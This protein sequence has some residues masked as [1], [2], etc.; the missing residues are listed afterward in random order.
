MMNVAIFGYSE[1]YYKSQLKGLLHDIGVVYDRIIQRG[2]TLPNNENAIRNEF[3]KYFSEQSYKAITTTAKDYYYDYEVS[4]Q[5]TSGRVDM[6]FLSPNCFAEQ[7]YFFVIECKR[8]DGRRK[9]SKEY[10]EN[11]I[12]RFT[13]G[14]YPSRLGCNAMLG[15]VVCNID[16][17]KTLGYVNEYLDSAEHLRE[18]GIATTRVSR[19][20]SNHTSPQP[21][22][23]YHL[24]MNFSD[25]IVSNSEN[26]N[27]NKY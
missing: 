21:I 18:V 13:T 25:R 16:I 23:L 14:K 24:W 4:L 20:E 1:A 7:D 5:K 6:R 8:I 17:N 27:D 2:D 12:Q 22:V 3:G 9:L 19:F 26:Q 10:V 15:F 11:G